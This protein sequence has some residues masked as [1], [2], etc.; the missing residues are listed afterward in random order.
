MLLLEVHVEATRNPVVAEIIERTDVEFRERFLSNV[1]K[2]LPAFEPEEAAARMEM[3]TAIVNGTTMRRLARPGP[4]SEMLVNVYRETISSLLEEKSLS[5]TATSV[6]PTQ[7]T[8]GRIRT[9][10]GK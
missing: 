2:D 3:L 10:S 9:C 7:Q 1:F 5:K 6:S 8:S 4:A